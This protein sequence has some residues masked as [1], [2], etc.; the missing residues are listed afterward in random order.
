[1]NFPGQAASSL[2]GEEHAGNQGLKDNL[3]QQGAKTGKNGKGINWKAKRRQSEQTR[4]NEASGFAEQVDL[5]E[6][7]NNKYLALKHKYTGKDSGMSQLRKREAENIQRQRE[8]ISELKDFKSVMR[9][10]KR[11]S[12]TEVKVAT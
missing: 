1:M 7:K 11:N 6:L 4:I 8:R 5:D 3:T 12:T 10:L 2:Y 9:A